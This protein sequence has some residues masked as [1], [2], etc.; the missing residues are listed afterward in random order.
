MIKN[1]D[2]AKVGEAVRRLRYERQ[3]QRPT[4]ASILLLT[5][6]QMGK[7]EAGEVIPKDSTMTL[8]SNV[9]GVRKGALE[10][11]EIVP[12]SHEWSAET[13]LWDL[14]KSIRQMRDKT[15]RL[16]EEVQNLRGMERYRTEPFMEE[17]VFYVIRD[18]ESGEFLRSETGE[19]YKFSDM[20]VALD[21]AEQLENGEM[22]PENI[23]YFDEFR[24]ELY[25]GPKDNSEVEQCQNMETIHI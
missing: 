25:T 6:E 5:D 7:I 24:D 12:F 13:T 10:C 16:L 9:F 4:L 1:E 14:E 2:M 19:V 21:T 23:R 8:M 22:I 20:Y 17:D 15:H 3:I 18:N 11:G